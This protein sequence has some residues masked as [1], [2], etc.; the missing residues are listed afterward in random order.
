MCATLCASSSSACSLNRLNVSVVLRS[1]RLTVLRGGTR[2]WLE[3]FI[4]SVNRLEPHFAFHEIHRDAVAAQELAADHAADVEAQQ[5]ARR[6]QVH[7]DERR[8]GEAD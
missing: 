5:R 4:V 7:D 6:I 1:L 2:S 3:K 8:A